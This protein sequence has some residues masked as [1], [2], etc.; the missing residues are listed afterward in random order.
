MWV[1][2]LFTFPLVGFGF[3]L[4]I[5]EHAS[6]WYDTGKSVLGAIGL[7]VLWWL[8]RREGTTLRGC[9]GRFRARHLGWALV[10]GLGTSTIS[11]GTWLIAADWLRRKTP[12]PDSEFYLF[13]TEFMIR[14]LVEPVWITF[15]VNLLFL[16]YALPRLRARFGP[17]WATVIVAF[18]S[19][20]VQL[21]YNLQG[22]V[23]MMISM[24]LGFLLAAVRLVPRGLRRGP[25][26]PGGV[27]PLR[28]G[29][30]QLALQPR[31]EGA[32]LGVGLD[33]PRDALGEYCRGATTPGAR[34]ASPAVPGGCAT[35][36][37][38][39]HLC[40]SRQAGVHHVEALFHA[41]A[42]G[43][44]PAVVVLEH[45]ELVCVPVCGEHGELFLQSDLEVVDLLVFRLDLSSGLCHHGVVR[46]LGDHGVLF[47]SGFVKN[48]HIPGRGHRRDVAATAGHTAIPCAGARIFR[49]RRDV[50]SSSLAR[51]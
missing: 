12:A 9:V 30:S 39:G 31:Q 46:V 26:A 29:I 25:G 8:L 3:W 14:A 21:G 17:V 37:R 45:G 32:Q 48:D 27:I 38:D 28:H 15:T 47:R 24:L 33:Q 36:G 19:G 11:L 49:T 40:L 42:L 23:T 5:S 16:G 35:C 18:C 44:E 2:S 41:F 51:H 20:L 50:H 34:G 1:L 22:P 13:S 6:R 43:V 10:V 7:V 4:Q